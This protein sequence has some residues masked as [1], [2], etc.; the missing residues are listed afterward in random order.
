MTGASARRIIRCAAAAAALGL[1]SAGCGFQLRGAPA[2][3][4]ESVHVSGGSSE[5][6][7]ALRRA[8][9][10]ES[11]TRIAATPK[12]ARARLR[13]RGEEREK[14]VLTLNAAG[15]VRESLLGYRVTFDVL[16]AAGKVAVA[17]SRI[18]LTREFPF[19]SSQLLAR[20]AEEALLYQDMQRDAVHQ[21]LRRLA[22][23]Q[24]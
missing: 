19:S 23:A 18:A 11:G 4:T 21:M 9:E 6:R 14:S 16:D 8:I 20:E 17:E 22:A 15:Q 2:L 24:L 13:I 10:A 7:L 5:L 1:A 3:A 12:E